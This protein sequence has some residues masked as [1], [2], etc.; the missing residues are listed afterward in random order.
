MKKP[1]KGAACKLNFGEYQYYMRRLRLATLA[2]PSR[3]AVFPAFG[4]PLFPLGFCEQQLEV[5]P[6]SHSNSVRTAASVWRCH[7]H[8]F[9][10]KAASLDDFLFLAISKFVQQG[11]HLGPRL[12]SFLAVQGVGDGPEMFASVMEIEYC[13]W[14]GKIGLARS[15]TA[16]RRRR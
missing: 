2:N 7:P 16:R 9:S 12:R 3:I 1:P 10:G 4:S 6:V 15:A 11:F 14:L 13:E 5:L 8:F